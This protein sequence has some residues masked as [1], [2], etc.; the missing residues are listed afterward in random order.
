MIRCVGSVR[1]GAFL[2]E[3]GISQDCSAFETLIKHRRCSVATKNSGGKSWSLSRRGVIGEMNIVNNAI[4]DMWLR[5]FDII[6]V[7]I[8]DIDT[9]V[10]FNVS[11]L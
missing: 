5:Q 11:L 1:P 3:V 8:L 10:I 9:K 2:L 4:N 6:I 7:L